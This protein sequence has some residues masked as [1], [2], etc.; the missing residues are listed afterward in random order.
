MRHGSK[1]KAKY[2][3]LYWELFTWKARDSN[4]Y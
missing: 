2:L 1:N 4:L 3:V